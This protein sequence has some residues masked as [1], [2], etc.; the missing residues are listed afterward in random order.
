MVSSAAGQSYDDATQIGQYEGAKAAQTSINDSYYHSANGLYYKV[1]SGVEYVTSENG[2]LQGYR[3]NSGVFVGVSSLT[4]I[5]QTA[6]NNLGVDAGK[7]G[8]VAGNVGVAAGHIGVSAGHVGVTAGHVGVAAGNIGVAEGQQAAQ[9]S[10]D[11]TYYHAN[12]GLYYKVPVGASCLTDAQ[13][14]FIGYKTKS[15]QSVDVS[16]I[17]GI[18]QTQY[19]NIG[20]QEGQQ[21][22]KTSIN[23]TYVHYNNRYY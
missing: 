6:Y 20:F 5:N 22:A 10:M 21:A 18:S 12:N 23:D 3:T 14:A 16:S 8:V 13:G 2:D 17:T 15:G 19:N 4:G 1:P 11:Y 9:T 7:V